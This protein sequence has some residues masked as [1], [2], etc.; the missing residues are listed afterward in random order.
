MRRQFNPDMLALARDL[1]GFTQEELVGRLKGKLSQATL[2]KIENGLVSPD[3]VDVNA[4]AE[5]LDVLPAFLRHPHLRRNQPSTYHRK[6]Q[7]LTTSEWSSI[8]AHAELLRIIASILMRSVDVRPK[9]PPLP[10]IDPDTHNGR[11]EEIAQDIRQLWGFPRG[12]VNDLTRYVESSGILIFTFDFGSELSD[13]FSQHAVDGMPACIFVNS[14]QPKERYR[15]T[16]AHEMAH[17]VMHRMPNPEMETQANQFAGALLMPASEIVGDLHN[18]SLERFMTLK[19]YWKVS[20]QALMMRAFHLRRL[21]ESAYKYYFV[22]M[23]KRGWRTREPVELDIPESPRF[24]KQLVSV[25]LNQLEYTTPDLA[26]LLGLTPAETASV[27][28]ISDGRPRL[29]IVT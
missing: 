28:N 29:R 22:Q 17:L 11:I 6:K 15:F 1:R 20:M 21:T 10:Y 19:M 7:K 4:L 16:L 8:Y 13:G 2:S 27:L 26:N 3:E 23:S 9:L 5:A 14:R 25:H 24:L 18:L 12:P